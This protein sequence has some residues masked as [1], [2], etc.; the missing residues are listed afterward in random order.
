[1]RTGKLDNRGRLQMLAVKGRPNIHLEARQRMRA[2]YDVKWV[3]IEDPNPTFRYT[4]G[5]EAPTSNDAALVAVGDQGRRRGAALF[6]RL[7]GQV[8]DNERRLLHLDPGWRPDRG[9]LGRRQRQRVRPRQRPGVGLPLPRRRS[10]RL[11]YQAPARHRGSEPSVRLPRQHHHEPSRD[12]R[13][14]RGQQSSTTTSAD[15]RAADSSGTSHSNRLVSSD[16]HATV[17]G[18]VRR[19][20]VPPGRAHAV[21]QHPGDQRHDVRDLGAVEAD[22]GLSPD[23]D[24]RGAAC[25]RRRTPPARP[26]GRGWRGR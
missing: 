5:Q 4:P 17:R 9:R 12:A 2:T 24:Q 23:L 8:Y 13:R 21:R 20:D 22:R 3:D 7:E 10:C 26:P 14:L 6:S 16:R 15:C 25:V 19:V 1:M 11:I 18:R